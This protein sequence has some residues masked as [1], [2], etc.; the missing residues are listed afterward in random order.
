MKVELFGW[1]SFEKG[2]SQGPLQELV[3]G[4]A[5]LM[6]QDVMLVPCNPGQSKH[7]FLLAVLPREKKIIVLDSKAGSFTKP[8][9]QH[10]IEKMWR[11]QALAVCNKHTKGCPTTAEQLRLWCI[12]L[13]FCKILSTPAIS[14]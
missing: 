8:T 2:F 14:S 10:A 13:L 1:E 3:K 4:K 12:F 5:H 6:E 11:L 9:T 7:W